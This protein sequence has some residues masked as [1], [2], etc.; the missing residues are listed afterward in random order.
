VAVVFASEIVSAAFGSDFDAAAH[1]T[2]VLMAAAPAYAAIGI[3]WYAL[4]ALGRERALVLLAGASAALALV[5]S[6]VLVPDGG[7]GGAA[8]AYVVALGIMAAAILAILVDGDVRRPARRRP[9]RRGADRAAGPDL[10]PG[11]WRPL[12]AGDP[13]AHGT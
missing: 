11:G 2:R 12:Q 3:G 6:L 10:A 1:S 13:G 5:L 8:V 9:L 7:D 4:V